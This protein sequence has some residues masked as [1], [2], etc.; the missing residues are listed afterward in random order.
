MRLPRLIFPELT[1]HPLHGSFQPTDDGYVRPEGVPQFIP[2]GEADFNVASSQYEL[3][4]TSG[5]EERLRLVNLHLWFAPD[6]F[7][8]RGSAVTII[9]SH[10]SLFVVR[11]GMYYILPLDR[12]QTVTHTTG[13]GNKHSKDML[14]E[15]AVVFYFS[16][17]VN[18]VLLPT[19][20]IPIPLLSGLLEIR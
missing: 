14:T 10:K 3:Y 1:Y 18:T 19:A 11:S 4:I 5:V 13:F 16:T 15:V 7:F 8:P 6:E 20:S 9:C 17:Y 2:I 12:P